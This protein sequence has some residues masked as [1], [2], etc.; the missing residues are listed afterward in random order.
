[1]ER[2]EY[3]KLCDSI[4][5]DITTEQDAILNAIPREMLPACAVA[6]IDGGEATGEYWDF[7]AE[8]TVIAQNEHDA[9]VVAGHEWSQS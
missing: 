6:V 4:G 8:Q 3:S 1:M 2:A 5:T 7:L 9:E